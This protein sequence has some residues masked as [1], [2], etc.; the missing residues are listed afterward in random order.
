MPLPTPSKDEEHDAFISRCMSE[1]SEEFPEDKQRAAVCNTQ[2]TKVKAAKGKELVAEIAAAGR[3]NSMSAGWVTIT[4]K[5]LNSIASA[6]TALR[7]KVKPPLKLGHNDKQPMTDGKP[8]L[9]WVTDVWVEGKKLMAKFSDVPDVLYDAIKA[10]RYRRVS[11]ELD[12]GVEVAGKRHDYVLSAVGLLGAD[13]PA[14]DTLADLQ[15]YLTEEIG[16]EHLVF[17]NFEKENDDM[18]DEKVIE[19]TGKLKDAESTLEAEKVAF[20]AEK[21]E[22]DDNILAL[23]KE[24]DDAL[25]KVK[26]LNFEQAKGSFEAKVEALLKEQKITPAQ[27]TMLVEKFAADTSE[28]LE[29]QLEVFEAGGKVIEFNEQ[30]KEG[31]GNEELSVGEKIVNMTRKRMDEHD[32]DWNTAQARV[33]GDNPDLAKQYVAGGEA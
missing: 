30:G 2:W 25:A 29:A 16:E 1:I 12:R 17:T 3:W 14:I 19:L 27:R 21:K 33:L 20:A 24:R 6:F 26:Q 23:T 22:L 7:D 28:G 4:E 11:V 18:S 10:K 8:A 5:H 15:T 32:E 9:G 13:I 31:Q